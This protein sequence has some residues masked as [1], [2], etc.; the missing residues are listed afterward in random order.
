ML[1]PVKGPRRGTLLSPHGW[2]L[3]RR[4]SP[5]LLLP[6]L[7]LCLRRRQRLHL[8]LALAL[9][10]HLHLHLHLARSLP[11]HLHLVHLLRVRVA[12][13]PRLCWLIR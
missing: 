7:C 4:L 1:T 3:P 8:A 13:L 2:Q 6:L 12:Q 11:L 9:H 10:L 5:R